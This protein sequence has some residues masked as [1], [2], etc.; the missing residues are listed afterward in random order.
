MSEDPRLAEARS[1]LRSAGFATADVE[2][3]GHDLGI[4]VITG[5]SADRAAQLAV[6]ASGFRALGFHY[7]TIDISGAQ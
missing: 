1:L 4:A 2:A 7:V 6:L 5:L 3:A